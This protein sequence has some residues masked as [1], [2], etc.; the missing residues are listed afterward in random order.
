MWTLLPAQGALN[1]LSK[2]LVQ[3]FSDLKASLLV[4]CSSILQSKIRGSYVKETSLNIQF[5]TL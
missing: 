5:F 1:K 3:T 2:L 4:S